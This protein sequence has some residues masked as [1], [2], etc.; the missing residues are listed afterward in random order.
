MALP[1]VATPKYSLKLPSNGDT[2][3]YRPFLVKEEKILL[4]AVES[5]DDRELANAVKT[6]IN[7]C[8]ESDDVDVQT[9]PVFDIEYLFLNLR[10]KS[11]GE[12]VKLKLKCEKCEH[13]CLV[14]VNLSDVGVIK[15]EGHD[16]KIQLTDDIGVVMR[17]P[18]F[19]M[20]D[21]PNM[22]ENPL[23]V[24]NMCIDKIYDAK[25]VHEAKDSTDEELSDFV[26]SLNHLQFEKI[27][28][29]FE[30]MPK[31]QKVINFK[32]DSCLNENSV[33]M[34]KLQDFFA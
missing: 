5:E 32:C 7:N 28:K 9:L 13:E 15:T 12:T 4:M 34:E 24:V 26:D 14:G 27:Q 18:T 1:K 6:I 16:S 19:G 3:N 21:S 33:T 8:I 2:I 10:S 31:M 11:V 17:Y 29:F 20:L 22:K 25:T 30:T 23:K